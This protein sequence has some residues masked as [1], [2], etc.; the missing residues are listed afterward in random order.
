MEN[1]KIESSNNVATPIDTPIY[2]E[3]DIDKSG[4][5][6]CKTYMDDFFMNQYV[7]GVSYVN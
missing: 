4:I 7:E 6:I 5:E 2:C 3:D 1:K